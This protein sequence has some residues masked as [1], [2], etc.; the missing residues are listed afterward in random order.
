MNRNITLAIDEDVLDRVRVIAAERKTTVNGMV[1]DYLTR[2][3]T[4][5]DRMA[6][7]RRRLIELAE[8]STARLGP[9]YRWNREE[10]YEDRVLPRHER[11]D[12]RGRGKNR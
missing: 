11:G 9:N 7:T 5:E 12:L 1:R 10:L 3:A 8:T 2:V 4:D 6:D